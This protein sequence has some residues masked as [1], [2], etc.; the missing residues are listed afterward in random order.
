MIAR[1]VQ[2]NN[3]FREDKNARGCFY[4]GV[5]RQTGAQK[6]RFLRVFGGKRRFWAGECE[7]ESTEK[8]FVKFI[9]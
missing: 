4:K 8:I 5:Q 3:F 1:F 7:K 6:G 9:L 2:K